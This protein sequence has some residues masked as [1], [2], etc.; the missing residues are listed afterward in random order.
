MRAFVAYA[1]A[2]GSL[3][4]AGNSQCPKALFLH[5]VCSDAPE[6]TAA[7]TVLA[8]L[9]EAP[10]AVMGVVFTHAD[11]VADEGEPDRRQQAVLA[12]VQGARTRPRCE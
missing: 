4:A 10:G 8:W 3:A 6:G 12:R 1:T 5:V 7:D 2:P 11:L 9:E